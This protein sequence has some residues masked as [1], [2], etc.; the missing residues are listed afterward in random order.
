MR[1]L[2]VSPDNAA[3]VNSWSGIPFHMFEALRGAADEVMNLSPLNQRL[4]LPLRA[5]A[6]A[7][8][9]VLPTIYR[10]DREPLIMHG[11]GR[12]ITAAAE[13][14]R[15][16]VIISCGSTPLTMVDLPAPCVFWADAT[17]HSLI[18]YYPN[19]T[20]LSRRHRR[21]GDSMEARALSRASL[22]VYASEWA[23]ASA[24]T[25]YGVPSEKVAIVPFGANFADVSPVSKNLEFSPVRLVSI[26]Q[27]WRR[28]GMDEAVEL[29][30]ELDRRGVAT[31][32][33]IVG[34]VPPPGTRLPP[35]V[36][37]YPY[38][39][40]SVDAEQRLLERLLRSA[41]FFV[42]PTRAECLGCALAEGQAYGLPTLVTR[43]GGAESMID[44]G[45][46]GEAYDFADFVSG[47]AKFIETTIEDPALYAALSNNARKLYETKFR[48]PRAVEQLFKEIH[49]RNLV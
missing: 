10:H 19:F 21:L 16:D 2:F 13:G 34:C 3:D 42:L 15:P 48:W 12:Q 46:T 31:T 14:F 45:R 9:K 49:N 28:K 43:T 25:H 5:F 22:A 23:A 40:K 1:V 18:D 32:L 35:L 47:A 33:D 4:G 11:Y 20:N 8:N 7:H 26:A 27:D 44:P 36:R 39:D 24:R 38:L 29:A 41:T 30:V 37:V 17:F 6:R